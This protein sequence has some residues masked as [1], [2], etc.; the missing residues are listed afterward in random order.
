MK[1]LVSFLA[2]LL[3][4]CASSSP[5]RGSTKAGNPSLCDIVDNVANYENSV[6]DISV[7]AEPALHGFGVSLTDAACPGKGIFLLAGSKFDDDKVF[8]WMLKQLYPG[9]PDDDGYQDVKVRI[10]A[11]GTIV[12]RSSRNLLTTFLDLQSI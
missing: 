1:I 6:V 3:A 10:R 8:I 9:Y 11:K 5:G 2:I 4:A 7:L 12:R